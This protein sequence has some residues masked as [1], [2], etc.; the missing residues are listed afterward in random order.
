[1]IFDID[2]FFRGAAAG[3]L[4][5]A[6]VGPIGILCMRRTLSGGR[7]SGFISGLGAAMA[8]ALYAAIAA[9]G[10]TFISEFLV[11]H[12]YA[13]RLIG[14][15]FLVYLGIKILLSR[16]SAKR[17]YD[18]AHTLTADFVSTFFLTITNP[19]TIFAFM[20]AF[21]WLGLQLAGG[22]YLAASFGVA[23]VFAG[24]ATWW[25]FLSLIVG[26]LGTRVGS[27]ALSI[28]HKVSGIAIIVFGA[29]VLAPAVPVLMCKVSW[30]W[31][32]SLFARCARVLPGF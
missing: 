18:R 5:A 27:R 21:A 4:L 12:Q 6:P 26:W 9:F 8:D 11:G 24:S 22:G 25:L 3:L 17:V 2:L 32:Q 7:I 15:I 14:G 23:G 1:M 29:L 20:S 30:S 16:P 31:C 13:L 19:M 10:L 28:I